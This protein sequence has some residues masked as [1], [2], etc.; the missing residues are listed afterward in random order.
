MFAIENYHSAESIAGACNYL[1]EHS[2]A[3]IIAGGTDVLIRLREGKSGFSHLMDVLEI[4]ELK[5]VQIADNGELIIGTGVTFSQL[6]KFLNEHQIC[7]ALIEGASSLGG[8]QV[9]NMA[10]IGGN[11]CNGAPS[12]DSAAPLL[13]LD[14]ELIIQNAQGSRRTSMETF[15]KGPG[16]VDLNPGELVTHICIQPD[17]YRNSSSYFY[18]YAMRQAMD[19]AT[20][21][22]SANCQVKDNRLASLKL[23]YTV[24][25]PVPKR[26]RTAEAMAVGQPVSQALINDI[27][28]MVLTDLSP[29]NSW[30]AAKDFRE[31]IIKTLA[32]KVITEA[33]TRAGG[34]IE[35]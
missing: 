4:A 16:W 6:I 14:A 8:P 33:I 30:R 2:D 15:Y 21:G 28:G 19:I 17:H 34:K 24:A 31:H 27:T 22:C 18:K 29:R 12:A 5:Q 9:R 10:T 1:A 23:A 32:E 20:I 13:T 25:A 3:R 7:Q 35:G 26:C 11:I